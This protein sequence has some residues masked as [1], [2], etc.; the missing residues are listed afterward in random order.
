VNKEYRYTI[1]MEL[2]TGCGTELTG[3]NWVVAPQLP[4]GYT[5][6]FIQKTL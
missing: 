6:K 2:C 4:A 1:E 5:L 3:T